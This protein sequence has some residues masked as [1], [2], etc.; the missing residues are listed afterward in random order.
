MANVFEN[1]GGKYAQ[2]A[3]QLKPLRKM[4]TGVYPIDFYLDGGFPEGQ[5]NLIAGKYHGGKTTLAMKTIGQCQLKY[6][7]KRSFWFDMEGAFDLATEKAKDHGIDLDNLTVLRPD[8]GGEVA[9]LICNLIDE[10]TEDVGVIV[11]DSVND[12]INHKEFDK[13][14]DEHQIAYNAS[15]VTKLLKRIKAKLNSNSFSSQELPTI[16][17]ISQIRANLGFGFKDYKIPGAKA[18]EHEPATILVTNAGQTWEDKTNDEMAFQQF[19]V[20]FDK[21]K[22]SSFNIKATEYTMC[23][24][25][26]QVLSDGT[27]IPTGFIDD[28]DFVISQSKALNMHNNGRAKQIFYT[29][30]LDQISFK[31]KDEV[32]CFF[33]SNPEQYAILKARL[34]AK[35]REVKKI[36]NNEI[37]LDYIHLQENLP[38]EQQEEEIEESKEEQ[39]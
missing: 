3:S 2:I 22:V 5:I 33:Y 28:I 16:L 13:D 7:H 30:E 34:L 4:P 21:V 9:D 31:S 35:R 14:A 38:V 27:P 37:Y 17:L 32:I 23:I 8:T 39:E 12:L 36:L 10:H 25:R 1:F 26:D 19:K 6:P 11:I 18:L 24:G 29:P 20:A 15:I